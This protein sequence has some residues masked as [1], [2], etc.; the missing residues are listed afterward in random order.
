VK[1]VETPLP[2]AYAVELEPHTDER[3]TFA[4]AYAVEEFVAAGLTP[5]GVQMNLSVNPRAGTLRGMHYQLAPAREAKLVRCVRGALFDVAVDLRPDSP[6]YRGWYGVELT[7]DNGRALYVPEGFA[8]G[9]LT[10]VDDTTAYYA[11]SHPYQPAAERGLRYDDPAVGIV[12]PR[13]VDLLSHKDATWP[14]LR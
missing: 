8:H 7:E 10:L 14:L 12:W 3:G 9:F 6:T 2:G 11:V 5:V 4:R 1:F 13:D